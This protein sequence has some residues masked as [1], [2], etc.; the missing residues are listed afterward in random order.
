MDESELP[1]TRA[2]VVDDDATCSKTVATMLLRLGTQQVESASGADEAM[3]L[4]RAGSFD[5]IFCDLNMPGRDGVETL[6]LFAEL[7]VKCPIVLVSGADPKILKA[8]HE[9]GKSRGLGV[10]GT[11]HKPFGLDELKKALRHVAQVASPRSRRPLPNV[12]AEELAR[13]IERQELVLHYQPQLNLHNCQLEGAEALVRWQHP[14]RGMLFP[15]AFIAL[16]ES[17][18]LIEPLTDWV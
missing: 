5:V 15:D 17:S 16:A 14:E 1:P 12:S 10:A 13:G 8:A 7:N 6:R 18:G 4:L 2:L 9:L 3:V 11:L